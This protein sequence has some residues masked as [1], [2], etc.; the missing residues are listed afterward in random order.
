MQTS[1]WNGNNWADG[2]TGKVGN[3]P[4]GGTGTICRKWGRGTVGT[5]TNVGKGSEIC[6]RERNTPGIPVPVP[7]RSRTDHIFPTQPLPRVVSEEIIAPFLDVSDGKL[8]AIYRRLMPILTTKDAAVATDGFPKSYVYVLNR[9]QCSLWTR[10][11][12][13]PASG[14]FACPPAYTLSSR[15]VPFLSAKTV[16]QPQYAASALTKHCIACT[17]YNILGSR[18]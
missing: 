7:I 13:T 2:G 18:K 1:G 5:E 11:V 16:L 8:M 15:T 17:T 6:R 14:P 10:H 9:E 12:L 4:Y 3:T